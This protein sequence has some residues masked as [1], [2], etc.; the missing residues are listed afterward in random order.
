MNDT[1]PEMCRKIYMVLREVHEQLAGIQP[2]IEKLNVRGY[3]TIYEIQDA[4]RFYHNMARIKED[5]AR[6]AMKVA[7]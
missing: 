2:D 6:E 4:I 5:D 7:S 1:S 3:A